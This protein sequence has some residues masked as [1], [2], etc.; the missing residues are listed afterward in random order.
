MLRD[1]AT[2]R[3]LRHSWSHWPTRPV[4]TTLIVNGFT[5]RS[6]CSRQ[7]ASAFAHS[8]AANCDSTDAMNDQGDVTGGFRFLIVD[9]DDAARTIQQLLQEG[10]PVVIATD[11][12]RACLRSET[13]RGTERVTSAAMSRPDVT[14]VRS[15]STSRERA[16]YNSRDYDKDRPRSGEPLLARG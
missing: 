16:T 7:K 1:G 15:W 10:D 13:L 6:R 9:H 5:G 8:D 3:A 14:T 4:P 11:T 2:S 12:T